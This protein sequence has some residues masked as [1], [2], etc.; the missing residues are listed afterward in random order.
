MIYLKLLC[1]ELFR[2]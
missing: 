2:Q 1:P